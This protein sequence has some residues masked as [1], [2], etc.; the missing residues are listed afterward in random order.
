MLRTQ[1]EAS[2]ATPRSQSFI[3]Y[4]VLIVRAKHVDVALAVRIPFVVVVP[5]TSAVRNL[6]DDVIYGD[7]APKF[8]CDVVETEMRGLHHV[9]I[10]PPSPVASPRGVH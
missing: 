7:D 10:I 3:G 9:V 2:W 4:V 5:G 6:K 1:L 8:F